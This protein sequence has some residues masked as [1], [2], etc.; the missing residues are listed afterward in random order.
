[1]TTAP[2]RGLTMENPKNEIASVVKLMTASNSPDIQRQAI[3][4]YFA[5][6]AGF[7]HPLCQVERGKNSRNKILGI[8]QWY[9]NMSPNIDLEVDEV[10][11]NNDAHKIYLNVSQRFH[12]FASP[13]PASTSK[14]LVQITLTQDDSGLYR[15]AQQDDYYQFEEIANLVIPPLAGVIVRAKQF[16]SYMSNLNTFFFQLFGI[17]CPSKSEHA[18]AD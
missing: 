6:D 9:R 2:F 11:Y 16:G 15:I 17:W 13:F 4:K 5:S 10:V 7:N 14:L 18:K 1:M 3:E 8:Y 12:I